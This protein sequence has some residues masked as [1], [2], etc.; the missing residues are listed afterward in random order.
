MIPYVSVAIKSV[1]AVTAAALLTAGAVSAAP[2]PTPSPS[3]AGQQQS[4]NARHHDRRAVRNAVIASEA[5][6]LG[7]TPKALVT[8]L[9]AGKSVSELAQAK[10]LTKAQFTAR[11]LV[12]LTHRLDNL[13]A[14]KVI[15][16][17]MEKKVLA[18]IAS[19]HI[20]FWNGIHLRK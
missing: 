13:V 16:P 15:T 2:S 1:G 8:A 4:D 14:R 17:A 3:A 5:D 19:G 9:K 12:E 10:G 20:P 7:V 11:F 6:V 18:R